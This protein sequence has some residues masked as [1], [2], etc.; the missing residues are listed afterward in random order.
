MSVIFLHVGKTYFCE[1]KLESLQKYLGGF[2][3]QPGLEKQ[4]K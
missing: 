1:E 2:I 4:D 3:S